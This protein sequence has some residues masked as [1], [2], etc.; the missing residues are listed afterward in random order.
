M[1]PRK[2]KPSTA[3][4]KQQQQQ[5]QQEEPS[6]T[7]TPTPPPASDDSLK[8][9][10][11]YTVLSV[12]PAAT[13]SEI[14]SAYLKLALR[15]HPDKLPAASTAD[16]KSAGHT[17]F[18]QLAFA[19][20]ILSDPDRKARY[21]ATGSTSES[22]F[23]V[24]WAEFYRN[25]FK[26]AINPSRIEEF[27]RKYQGSE[28]ERE[29]VLS[30]YV[31]G[32]GSVKY[33]FEHVMC[34]EKEADLE[35]YREMVTAAVEEGEVEMH[36][37]FWEEKVP[38]KRVGEGKEA[39]AYARKLGVYEKL[40]GK[41][42]EKDG[43]GGEEEEEEEEGGEAGGERDGEVEVSGTDDDD[44]DEDF[45]LERDKDENKDNKEAEAKPQTKKPKKS[46][47]KQPKATSSSSP[48]SA[49]PKPK[50][51]NPA[52]SLANLEELIRSRQRDR[53]ANLLSNIENRYV[54][55]HG[56]RSTAKSGKGRKRAAEDD[57]GDVEMEDA[58][59]RN[60]NGAS[61]GKGKKG[62]GK[63]VVPPPAGAE[64]G[65]STRGEKR[66]K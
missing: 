6:S 40:F 20:G 37:R 11:P 45:T 15:L 17:K 4:P 10:N 38:K 19:Y 56:Q 54:N 61:G 29:H 65:R 64:G 46:K 5:Q 2:S 39:M 3:A 1:P 31:E 53:Y 52:S 62:R 36:Q 44:E 35:R 47:S 58:D 14:R 12:P 28:E 23:G 34:S 66:R 42:E 32:E 30:A 57:D 27:K 16:E 24:D 51:P 63:K 22:A 59:G 21:D 26:D 49:K 18:Q 55:N 13:T 33:V 60:G 25:Q 48:S 41:D 7:P 8:N 9:L 50:A 43:D